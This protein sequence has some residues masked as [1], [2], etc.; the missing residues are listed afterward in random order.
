MDRAQPVLVIAGRA[1][2]GL[3]LAVALSALGTGL[4]WGL[5]VFSGARSFADLFSLFML[6]A[7]LG[8]GLGSFLAWLSIDRNTRSRLLFM[9]L[10]ALAVGIAGAWGGYEY[11]ARQEVECCAMPTVGPMTYA[12]VG[13]A[14]AANAALLVFGLIRDA[15]GRWRRQTRLG[16]PAA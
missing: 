13:A 3:L 10:L 9:G 1:V 14:L 16:Y 5:Y 7:G 6:G 8:A 2:L 12:A 11:G 4:A 15:I